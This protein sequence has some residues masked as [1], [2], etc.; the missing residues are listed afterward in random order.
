MKNSRD[1]QPR[2]LVIDDESS[3]R[4]VLEVFL[5]REGFVPLLAE[6]GG[7]GITM[8]REQRPDVIILDFIMPGMDGLEVLATL[9]GE[10]GLKE[11]PVIMCT[12]FT[13]EENRRQALAL[14]AAAYLNKPFD[15]NELMSHIHKLLMVKL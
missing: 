14:G 6:S 13:R 3:I 5:K 1:P 10:E 8:A 2:I 7:V 15:I 12:V 4:Q 11:I 9:K